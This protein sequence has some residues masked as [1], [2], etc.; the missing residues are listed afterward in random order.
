MAAKK[1]AK[2]Y[3]YGKHS[4]AEALR[5]APRA[6]RSLYLAEPG[7]KAL[8]E[9]AKNAGIAVTPLDLRRA[10]SMT[11]GSE[12]HQGA[13]ALIG[14]TELLLDGER[15]AESFKPLPG[16]VLVF[17]SEVQDPHNVGAIIRSAAAF[18]AAAVLLPMHKQ[19]PITAAVIRASAGMAFQVP[20]VGVAN[21][22]QTI[23]ALKKKGVRVL[24]LAADG[25]VRLE[26][27]PFAEPTML[28]L[29]NEAEGV[30][31]YAR[32]LCDAMLSIDIEPKAESL[33][34]AASA[35]VALYAARLRRGM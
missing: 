11:D 29:G 33:N 30:A 7:D 22:Q 1:P 24:G 4:V 20:L 25:A 21:P 12:A 5:H 26:Q 14:A 31:P 34:V 27:E 17:L 32:A 15:F 16:S 18:G 23:A 6:V 19:S 9:L 10:T 35:A 13:V 28:V 8:Y 2:L 3:I